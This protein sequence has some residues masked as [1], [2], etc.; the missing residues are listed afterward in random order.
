[1]GNPSASKGCCSLH[2]YSPA[3]HQCHIFAE[4]TDAPCKKEVSI[5]TAYGTV[6]PFMEKTVCL[7]CLSLG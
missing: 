4:E 7:S 3:Y 1:M 5:T 2:V 6:Y